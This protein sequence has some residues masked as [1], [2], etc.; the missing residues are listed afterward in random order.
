MWGRGG[1]SREGRKEWK[2]ISLATALGRITETS[3][4]GNVSARRVH[5]G[6]LG[7]RASFTYL[8]SAPVTF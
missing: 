2:K 7:E 5:G 8:Q 4:A 1:G 3:R 6:Y